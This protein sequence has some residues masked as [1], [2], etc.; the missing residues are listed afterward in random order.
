MIGL[1]TETDADLEAIA[2]ICRKVRDAARQG[3]PSP[4]GHCGPFALCSQA[5]HALPVGSTDQSGR[6]AARRVNLV[7]T[8]F[9]G[10]KFLKLRWHEPAIGIWKAYCRAQTAAWQTC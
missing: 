3:R 10:Q 2:D 6:N 8:Q 1:P 4:S 5:V 7:R 9:K